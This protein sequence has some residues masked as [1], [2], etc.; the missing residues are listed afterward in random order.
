MITKKQKGFTLIELLVVIA[1]IGILAGILFFAIDPADQKVRAED[2][3]RIAIFNGVQKALDLYLLDNGHYPECTG[4]NTWNYPGSN[5]ACFEN[6]LSPYIKV[7]I[8][9]YLFSYLSGSSS[10]EN[11]GS[12]FYYTS[13]S[14]DN[15]QTYGMFVSLVHSDNNGI[16]LNTNDGGYWDSHYEAGQ[17][18][19]YCAGKYSGTGADWYHE[20]TQ[21]CIGGN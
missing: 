21:L 7:D 10:I 1:I 18:P 3:K 11:S 19:R 12:G 15:Y 17:L 2:A 8:D 9:S 16:G 20:H 14:V 13:N 4:T 6:A 5:V